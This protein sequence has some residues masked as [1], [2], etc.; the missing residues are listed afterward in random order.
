MNFF[1]A[2]SNTQKYQSTMLRIHTATANDQVN[3]REQSEWEWKREA[4]I[5]KPY[6]TLDLIVLLCAKYVT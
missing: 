5:L 3:S 1:S 4:A 6:L 2:S